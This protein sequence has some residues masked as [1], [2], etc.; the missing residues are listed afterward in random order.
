METKNR[1]KVLAIAAAAAAGLWLLN[2]IVITPL[3]QSWHNR[4][5]HIR[6]LQK[7]ISEGAMLIRRQ[8]TVRDRWDYM[9]TNAL[10]STATLAEGQMFTAFDRW[11]NQS[12]VTEGS[13]RPQLHETDD[14]YSTIDCKADVSGN[15]D[16]VL[17]FLKKMEKDPLAIKIEALELT[18]KDDTGR[19]LTLS[20][21]LSGL[22]LPTPPSQ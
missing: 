7:K 3:T 5:D 10:A 13:F 22:L 17:S 15:I 8:A 6:D 4:S 20:M 11:V 12:A 18:S 19:Q 16:T 21:D 1:E 9:R 14:G 2:L